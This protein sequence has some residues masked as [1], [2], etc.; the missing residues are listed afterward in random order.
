M[1]QDRLKGDYTILYEEEEE[2]V[3]DIPI[4]GMELNVKYSDDLKSLVKALLVRKPADRLGYTRDSEEILEHVAFK[5][6]TKVEGED[7][8]PD[9][10]GEGF[11]FQ[12][13]ELYNMDQD[14]DKKKKE[15][16]AAV[17]EKAEDD[18]NEKEQDEFA[19]FFP[20]D[21]VASASVTEGTNADGTLAS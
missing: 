16:D 9:D 17:A 4:G 5:L 1:Y 12:K 19:V 11:K 7:G 10:K 21:A 20:T 14:F 15:K 8:S 18:L 6:L 13:P 3:G 2:K